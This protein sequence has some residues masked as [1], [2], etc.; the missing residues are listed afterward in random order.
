MLIHSFNITI[1]TCIVLLLIASGCS[2]IPLPLTYM[3]SAKSG[4][5]IVQLLRGE[6]TINDRIV[7]SV[8]EKTCYTIAWLH[9]KEYCIEID[10]VDDLPPM[11]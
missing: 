8:V 5:D 7:S 6:Q 4:I 1:C 3:S 9:G 2:F 10:P 11:D